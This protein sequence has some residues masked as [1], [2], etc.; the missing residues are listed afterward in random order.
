MR[1]KMKRAWRRI[2]GIGLFHAFLYL[3]LV[4]RVIFPRF[5]EEGLAFAAAMALVVSAGVLGILWLG[6]SK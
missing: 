5:G 4:P 6:K 3:Y 2:V 1:F